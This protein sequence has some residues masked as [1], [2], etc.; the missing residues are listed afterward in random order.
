MSTIYKASTTENT[1]N[2]LRRRLATTSTFAKTSK[3]PFQGKHEAYLDILALVDNYN[4][5]IR[6]V[7]QADQL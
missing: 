2:Q 6:A 1:V 4:Y 3:V 5:N 7:D